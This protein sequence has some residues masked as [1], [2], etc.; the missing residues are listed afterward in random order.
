MCDAF[1]R[2]EIWFLKTKN[3]IHE[4]GTAIKKSQVHQWDSENLDLHDLFIETLFW[5]N[6]CPEKN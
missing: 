4:L 2:K 3:I 1:E 6:L 5:I